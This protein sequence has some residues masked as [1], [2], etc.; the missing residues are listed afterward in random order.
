MH[1]SCIVSSILLTLSTLYPLFRAIKEKEVEYLSRWNICF[2]IIESICLA[3]FGYLENETLLF[4]SAGAK[5][6]IY[7]V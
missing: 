3:I 4:A 6:L 2:G 7:F 5:I 1:T